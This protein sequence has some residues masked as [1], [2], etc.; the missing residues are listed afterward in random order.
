MSAPAG[1]YYTAEA[2]GAADLTTQDLDRAL[3][4]ARVHRGRV[5]K[6]V[7]SPSGER[8]DLGMHTNYSW[9]PS[10]LPVSP[11]SGE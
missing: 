10:S 6:F 7:I 2:G 9:R 4:Y 3:Q 8:T 11:R 1:T 5:V